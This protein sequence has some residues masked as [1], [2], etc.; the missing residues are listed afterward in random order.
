M[1]NLWSNWIGGIAQQA[2]LVSSYQL[3][4]EGNTIKNNS[5]VKPGYLTEI[6]T[7]VSGNLVLKAIDLEEATK[8]AKHSPILEM[9]GCVEIRNVLTTFLS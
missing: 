4:F 1:K 8:M 2:R 3:G 5:E 6:K 9:G 7:S